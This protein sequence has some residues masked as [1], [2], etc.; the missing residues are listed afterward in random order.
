MNAFIL[1]LKAYP[2]THLTTACEQ[3][4]QIAIR[5]GCDVTFDF[6]G[7]LMHAHGGKSA[8]LMERQY[9]EWRERKEKV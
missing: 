4:T 1:E 7:V 2:G 9:H 8:E 5:V 3:A 6:N